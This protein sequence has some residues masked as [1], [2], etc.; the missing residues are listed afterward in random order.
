[1]VYGRT[2]AK[3]VIIDGRARQSHRQ[4]KP[5]AQWRILLLDNHPGYI[6]WEDLLHIPTLLAAN[7]NRP[8]EGAGGAAKRGPALLSGWLRCGRCGRKL[9]VASS[10]TTGRVPRYVCRGGRGDRA[11]SS[12]W[13][14]GG[15]RGD[16]AVEAAVLEALHPAGIQAAL[17]ALEQ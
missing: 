14:I 3:T 8:Q 5:L 10:G 12:C 15:L 7:S 6:S 4:K 17:E 1:L 2:A 9:N 13:T 16:R 11:S